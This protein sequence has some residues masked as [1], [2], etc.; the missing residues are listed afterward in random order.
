MRKVEEFQETQKLM[1]EYKKIGDKIPEFDEKIE[2]LNKRTALTIERLQEEMNQ[3]WEDVEF[4]LDR[5]SVVKEYEK[6]IAEAKENQRKET[7]ELNKQKEEAKDNK[8]YFRTDENLQTIT[9][10]IEE[11]KKEVSRGELELRKKDIELLEFYDEENH[12]NPLRW[13]EIYNE[14]D[15]IKKDIKKL[16]DKIE[17]YSKFRDELKSI[18]LTTAEFKIMREREEKR[19]NIESKIQDKKIEEEK[20][21]EV[22]KEES[23]KEEVKEGSDD[24]LKTA[25][26]LDTKKE[27][28]KEEVEKEEVKKDSTNPLKTATD[29]DTKKEVKKKEVKKEEVKKEEVKKEEVKKVSTDPLK[30]ATDLE[31]NTEKNEVSLDNI[32]IVISK[33]G[34]KIEIP[35]G[36]MYM[37]KGLLNF[38]DLK[39]DRRNFEGQ[40][41]IEFKDNIEK[42]LAGT[43]LTDEQIEKIDPNILSALK[44]IKNSGLDINIKTELFERYILAIKTDGKVPED[45]SLKGIIEY[46]RTDLDYLKPRNIINRI[47]HKQDYDDIKYYADIAEE[48]GFADVKQDQPGIIRKFFNKIK[49]KIPLFAKKET[50]LLEEKTKSKEVKSWEATSDQKALHEAMERY[51]NGEIDYQE[52]VTTGFKGRVER[53]REELRNITTLDDTEFNKY[54]EDKSEHDVSRKESIENKTDIH[55]TITE[56]DK[57]DSEGR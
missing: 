47:I 2:L 5:N 49:N 36:E 35:D 10:E 39:K 7:E 1:D 25:T 26:D 46:D 37:D 41:Y 33:K 48:K 22:N 16:N 29:L 54:M 34:L 15:E 8:K 11:M 4:N 28:K 23:K 53:F 38:R 43:S 21:V 42:F 44:I 45:K 31:T 32:K 17:E 18:D 56:T 19:K 9:M 24:P 12:E 6:K 20:K 50:K 30:T 13:Q 3:N 57:G 55:R 52:E 27:V 14:K 51:Y 40:D